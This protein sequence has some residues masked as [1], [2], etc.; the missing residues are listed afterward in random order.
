MNGCINGCTAYKTSEKKVT[1]NFQKNKSKVSEVGV[2]TP[3]FGLVADHSDYLL[4]ISTALYFQ[5]LNLGSKLQSASP[6]R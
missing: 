4:C 3:D 6:V 2:H 1:T 5:R